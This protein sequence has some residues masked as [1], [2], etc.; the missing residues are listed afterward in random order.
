MRDKLEEFILRTHPILVGFIAVLI[1]AVIVVLCIAFIEA[2]AIVGVIVFVGF[3]SMIFGG[4]IKEEVESE[5][6]YREIVERRRNVK[7]D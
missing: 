4:W 2:F 3:M 5:Q 6:R 7:Q 1:L